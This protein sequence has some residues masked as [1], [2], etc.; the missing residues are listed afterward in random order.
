[1][2]GCNT[3]QKQAESCQS[4]FFIFVL[5][6]L[7]TAFLFVTQKITQQVD[8]TSLARFSQGTINKKV[9][10]IVKAGNM[11]KNGPV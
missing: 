7:H 8:E 11:K 10:R 6:H 1:M 4:F 9:M 2:F 3:I 5:L